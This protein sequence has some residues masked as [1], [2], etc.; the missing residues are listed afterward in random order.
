MQVNDLRHFDCSGRGMFLIIG[1]VIKSTIQEKL[2]NCE[3]IGVFIDEVTDISVFS[4]FITFVEF[5]DPNSGKLLVNLFSVDNVLEGFDSANAR[6]ISELVLKSFVDSDVPFSRVTGFSSDGASVMLGKNTGVA[7]R[8]RDHNPKLINIHCVCH[9]LALACSDS[10]SEIQ[11]VKQIQ[12]TL[13][14][15]WKYLK[16]SP[17]RMAIYLKVQENFH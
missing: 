8:L 13:F 1:N 12:E 3:S 4:Q 9:K 10:D 16:N 5:V 15:L 14:G 11:C 17:K 2:R 6:A 7:A